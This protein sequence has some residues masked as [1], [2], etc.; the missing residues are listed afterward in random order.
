MI[1]T[2]FDGAIELAQRASEQA[3]RHAEFARGQLAGLELARDE[4]VAWIGK[5]AGD[6]IGAA[7]PGQEREAAINAGA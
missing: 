5:S 6:G 1:K 2:P 4:F 3:D 7:E